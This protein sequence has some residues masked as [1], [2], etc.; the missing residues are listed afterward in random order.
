VG[1][2]NVHGYGGEPPNTLAGATT[3]TVTSTTNE[4]KDVI[5]SRGPPP[6]RSPLTDGGMD[7]MDRWLV[8]VLVLEGERED[9]AREVSCS[10]ARPVPPLLSIPKRLRSRGCGCGFL[11]IRLSPP[12]GAYLPSLSVSCVCEA[13]TRV[14]LK[15]YSR[16]RNQVERRVLRWTLTQTPHKTGCESRSLAPPTLACVSSDASLW[17][18]P[19]AA[20]Q[21][22]ISPAHSLRTSART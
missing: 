3:S 21:R 9:S 13:E 11:S 18:R 5:V 22:S 8:E 4:T 2:E 17:L 20:E 15:I 12:T 1:V 14:R 19:R 7:G 6:P 16:R 10:C